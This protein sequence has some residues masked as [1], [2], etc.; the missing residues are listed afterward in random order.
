MAVRLHPAFASLRDERAA[1]VTRFKNGDLDGPG[2]HAALS[3]AMDAAI[4][5]VWL[6]LAVPATGVAL[7]ALGGYGRGLLAPGSDVDLMI[8]HNGIPRIGDAG[9]PLWYTLWDAGIKVGHAV[10][11]PKESMSLAGVNLEA[12]T[13]FLDARML[14]G[15]TDLFTSFAASAKAF[16]RKRDA[17]FVA[18]VREM[19]RLRH[20]AHGS[21]TSQLEPNIKE[22]TGG[23]RDLHVLDWFAPVVGDLI[24]L[25]LLDEAARDE[26]DRAHR[27][28]LT[29][30][31][32]LHLETGG[33]NDSLLFHLQRP[34]ALAMG[35]RDD[36]SIAEDAFMRDLFVAT[37]AV[38][39]SVT[40]VGADLAARGSKIP[41]T[42]HRRG[43]FV[44]AGGRV[45]LE[46]SL[47]IARNPEDAISLF[48]LGATPGAA[49]LR[50]VRRALDGATVPMTPA[51]VE[52]FL[53]L[54]RTGSGALLEMAD[55]VGVFAALFG[56]WDAVRL[57][58][59]RNVYH[60]YTVDAH[61]FH[62]AHA[63]ATMLRD[64]EP[65]VIDRV[66][67]DLDGYSVLGPMP[68]PLDASA[69]VIAIRGDARLVMLLAPIVAAWER[70]DVRVKIDV[71]PWDL[72]EERWRS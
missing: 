59:Q 14:E 26:L 11:T 47:E 53:E 24:G 8:L 1:L 32:H 12:E 39:L 69:S 6:G 33:S 72:V 18:D 5:S 62:T 58:P 37:R 40:T 25:Q 71:D 16:S 15:D 38:E 9:Q 7:V 35:Y 68:D 52:A 50:E 21:A 42:G 31:A 57:Q 61:L 60:R 22:G 28:L 45:L 67:A 17:R 13:S 51:V 41:R 70:D 10:R 56:E 30:R 46:R 55:H 48:L 3:D 20:A 27:F 36:G 29:A 23:L 2:L 65:G 54:L 43:P 64:H 34:V 44:V 66:V 19:M 49:A 63:A 4:R